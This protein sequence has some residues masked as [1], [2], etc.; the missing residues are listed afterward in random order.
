MKYTVLLLR[1][2]ELPFP[3][4]AILQKDKHVVRRK[5]LRFL[6]VARG[7]IA[8]L[9]TQIQISA[10][11]AYTTQTDAH[12]LLHHCAAVY[13]LTNELYGAIEKRVMTQDQPRTKN[14]EPGTHS[15]S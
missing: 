1:C 6:S 13:H 8:E 14:Q 4:L 12:D 7:S 11:L 9:E 2:G 10:D 3:C 5:S 15:D